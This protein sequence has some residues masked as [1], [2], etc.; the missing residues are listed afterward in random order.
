M[1]RKCCGNLKKVFCRRDF[2][3]LLFLAVSTIALSSVSSAQTD[4]S[5]PPPEGNVDSIAPSS[6]PADRQAPNGPS[7]KLA[8][9][10][11]VDALN[12]ATRYRF[13]D[14]DSG[15]SANQNQYQINARWRFKFDAKGK[16]SIY[17]ALHTG[18]IFTSGWD[19]TGWGTGDAQNDINLK[20]LYFDAK[21]AKWIEVQV[22]GIAPTNGVNTEITGY[23]NDGYIMGERAT[24]RHPKKLYFDEISATNAFIGDLTTPNVFRRFKRLGNSNYHQFLV[25]KQVNKR[26]RFSADYT[27]ESGRDF[28]RQ[29]INV[30][31]GE[32]K[33][34]DRIVFENYQRLDPDPGYGFSVHGEKKVNNRVSLGGG[35]T[36]IDAP[37]LNADRFPPGKRLFAHGTYKLTR[38]LSLNAFFVQAVGSLPTP[39]SPRTRLD[40]VLTFNILE[41]FHR[42][43]IL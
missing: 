9:W 31:T 16:Y 28:L 40:V 8:R 27:F 43:K 37:M 12:V 19:N 23:D 17:A 15:L 4:T 38:E 26:V 35:F 30:G 34:L 7:N 24:I 41:V 29:A 42:L 32:L 20:Q 36:N 14:T 18:A 10:L 13:V 1:L 3:I 25:S 22:G 39:I 33:F 11:E 21:P 6:A 2:P 5:A